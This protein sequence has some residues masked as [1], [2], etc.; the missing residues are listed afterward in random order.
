M[1]LDK[2]EEVEKLGDSIITNT[3]SVR[4]KSY[5]NYSKMHMH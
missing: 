1:K 4:N 2:L 5:Q 3:D